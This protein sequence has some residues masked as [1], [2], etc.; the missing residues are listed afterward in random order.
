MERDAADR[1][2]P[3]GKSFENEADSQESPNAELPPLRI[4]H[5][6]A[7]TAVFSCVMAVSLSIRRLSRFLAAETTVQEFS[8]WGVLFGTVQLLALATSLT[9]LLFGGMWRRERLPFPSQPG[10]WIAI[11]VTSKGCYQI[12]LYLLTTAISPTHFSVHMF[13]EIGAGIPFHVALLIICV[14]AY[15]RE[16]IRYW[17]WGWVATAVH[18]LLTIAMYT[19]H[20]LV[21]LHRL[22]YSLFWVSSPINW[23]SPINL[24]V[25][26]GYFY[27]LIVYYVVFVFLLLAATFDMRHLRRRHWSHWAV[28]VTLGVQ[29]SVYIVYCH[30]LIYQNF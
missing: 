23:N 13:L 25:S 28:L 18:S 19:F 9:V 30:W 15:R 29:Y 3:L 27:Q 4:H 14:A 12:V 1:L 21:F 6:L 24:S 5:L 22:L 26:F 7:W 17:R 16:P 20:A 2:N 10:H 11:Y 8:N